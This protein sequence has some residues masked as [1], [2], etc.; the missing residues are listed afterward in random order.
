MSDIMIG[1]GAGGIVGSYTAY[2]SPT[3]RPPTVLFFS[4]QLDHGS[5]LHAQVAG[6]MIESFKKCGF[7]VLSIVFNRTSASSSKSD[8]GLTELS[9]AA[10]AL[11]WLRLQGF[12]SDQVWVSGFSFGSWIATQLMM[13]RPEIVKFVIASPPIEKHDFNFL[14][15]CPI[16]GLVIQGDRD[17]FAPE[18]KVKSL[19]SRMCRQKVSK[20]KYAVVSDGDHFY[21]DQLDELRSLMDSYINEQLAQALPVPPETKGRGARLSKFLDPVS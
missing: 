14:S 3:G 15:P 21:R 6:A 11:N 4:Q 1:G 10:A 17:S 18:D 5:A 19:H 16:P 2:K 7:S 20:V 13:R 9:D 8:D 12:E